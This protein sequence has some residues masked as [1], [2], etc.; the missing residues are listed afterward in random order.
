[1]ILY[2][3]TYHCVL[4]LFQLSQSN[5]YIVQLLF[6]LCYVYETCVCNSMSHCSRVVLYV[7]KKLSLFLTRFFFSDKLHNL[8]SVSVTFCFHCG[9][10][11]HTIVCKAPSQ[12]NVCMDKDWWATSCLLM[13]I[14][15]F[16][17]GCVGLF[18]NKRKSLFNTCLSLQWGSVLLSGKVESWLS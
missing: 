9:I 17:F 11:A 13:H 2:V 7:T 5:H 15:L 1:M 16:A 18:L 12:Q 8:F 10:K 3:S 4:F 14:V 6:K